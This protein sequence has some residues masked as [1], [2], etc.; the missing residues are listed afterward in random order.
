MVTQMESQVSTRTAMPAA[1]T[2]VLVGIDDSA[3]SLVAVKQAARLTDGRLTL[4][5]V[6]DPVTSV[7]GG[8]GPAVPARLDEAP[9]REE[10]EEALR[11]AAAA[12]E[13]TAHVDTVRRGRSWAE[14][15]REVERGG[16]DLVAIGSHGIGRARGILMGS[17]ATEL[18]H[19][20]PCSVLVARP[21][22]PE[23]PRRIVVGVDGSTESA[24]AYAVAKALAERYGAHLRPL[25]AY[26]DDDVDFDAVAAILGAVPRGTLDM[27]VHGLVKASLESD[28]VVVGS[29][30]LT[31][32][33]ALGSVSERV[34]HESA[35]SVLIVRSRALPGGEN[36]TE[37]A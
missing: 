16:H 2:D 26:C 29:R 28:L 17:T 7:I 18:T 12:I 21:A 33:K 34:A 10:A 25:V 19:K 8:L 5:A 14:L 13:P 24:A 37:Q 15:I 31:G 9:L 3:Q 6:Y 30:G 27:A 36:A 11:R 4:M 35:C 1:F 20:A 32:L 22:P 23:F